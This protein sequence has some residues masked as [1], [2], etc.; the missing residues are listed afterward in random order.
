MINKVEIIN[1]LFLEKCNCGHSFFC[2]SA[3]LDPMRLLRNELE[4]KEVIECILH[5]NFALMPLV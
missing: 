5:V 2:D 4:A 3:V 1:K